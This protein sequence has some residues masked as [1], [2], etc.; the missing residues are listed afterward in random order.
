MNSI[1]ILNEKKKLIKEKVNLEIEMKKNDEKIKQL[2]EECN[3]ELVLQFCDHEPHK[4]GTIYE[5]V[6]PFC[7]KKEDIHA[8]Y[9]LDKSSFNNSKVIDLSKYSISSVLNN[10][11]SIFSLVTDNYDDFVSDSYDYSLFDENLEIDEEDKKIR[12]YIK[13][14]KVD[15]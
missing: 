3:H 6:C 4:I 9:E 13:N 14:N 1:E 11:A 2:Q 8:F 10:F 15:E 12:K 7:G 5:C